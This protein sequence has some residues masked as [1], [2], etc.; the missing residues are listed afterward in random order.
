MLNESDLYVAASAINGQGLFCKL[1]ITV[2]TCI[3]LIG[4]LV[5]ARNHEVWITYLGGYVNHQKHCNTELER[6]GEEFFLYANR[7]IPAG[8]ELTADY[9][10]LP[11]MFNKNVSG[12]T[13]K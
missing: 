9:T 3:A 12:Y 5:R 7:F 8:E 10:I 13:E 4:D 2:N 11:D 6:Y 1:D